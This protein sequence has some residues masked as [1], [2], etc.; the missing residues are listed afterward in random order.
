[1]AE[2]LQLATVEPLVVGLAVG[3][4]LGFVVGL[5]LGLAVV[6]GLA[7]G[8]EVGEALGP[9]APDEPSLLR[10]VSSQRTPRSRA[11]ST[12]TTITR[13]NQ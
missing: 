1:M 13:R 10:P 2:S 6:D 11:S 7:D 12:T 5:V 9:A 4:V 8:V 3:L